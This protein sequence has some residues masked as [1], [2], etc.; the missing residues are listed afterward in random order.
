LE[1]LRRVDRYGITRRGEQYAGWKALPPGAGDAIAMPAA[2]TVDEAARML[3]DLADGLPADVSHV[4]RNA[5][6]RNTLFRQAAAV[7]HPDRG[8]DRA[9]WDQLQQARDV[10]EQHA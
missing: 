7:H 9:I 10:L 2:M 6:I 4:R 8:G 5:R 1:A 3:V